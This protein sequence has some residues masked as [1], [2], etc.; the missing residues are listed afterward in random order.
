MKIRLD[1]LFYHFTLSQGLCDVNEYMCASGKNCI[2][3]EYLCDGTTD[4]EDNDDEL[5]CRNSF[6]LDDNPQ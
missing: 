5:M 3:N 6:S 1:L 2:P 4:C